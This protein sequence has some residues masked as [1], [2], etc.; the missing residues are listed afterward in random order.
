MLCKYF[1]KLVTKL[2]ASREAKAY[3]LGLFQDQIIKP[4]DYSKESIVLTYK[5]AISSY[6]VEFI[7]SI[8][9]WVFWVETFYYDHIKDNKAVTESFGRLSYY[10]CYRLVPS[11]SV[12]EE[13]ADNLPIYTYKLRLNGE[14]GI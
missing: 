11:W 7:Q 8:G 9:D 6:N 4:C 1:H 3:I 10:R 12:Y 13:L 14:G 2:E 5:H